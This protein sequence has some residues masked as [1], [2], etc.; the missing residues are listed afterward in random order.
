MRPR[1]T[2][3]FASLLALLLA[4]AA[5]ARQG[6]AEKVP[7]PSAE[8]ET[9]RFPPDD[10]G[11]ASFEA[12]RKAQERAV[13]EIAVPHGFRFT[14]QLPASGITFEHQVPADARLYYKPVHYDH[15]SPVVAADV[16]G[17][18]LLD[19][20]FLSLV[21]GNELWR[22]RGDGTF[23]EITARAGVGL[24]DRVGM[25]ASFADYDNDGDQDLFVTTVKTGNVLFANQGDG[26]F[27]DV[28]EKVGLDHVGHSSTGVF[29]D[30]D[31]DG[32]LD[33][34]LTNVGVYTTDEK[35]DYG[36]YLGVDDAFS[37]HL[38]PERT[39]R[40]IL[41]RNIEGKR[42]DDVSRKVGLV[43]RSW[44]G[45]ASFTDFDRDGWPELYVLNMQGDDHYYDNAEG[46]AFLDVTGKHFPKSPWGS[47]GVAFFDF[48]NDTRL[49]LILTDMHSDMSKQVPPSEETAK[50]DMQWPDD[51]LQGGEDNIFGNAFWVNQGDGEFVERSEALGTE[52]Y[53]PWGLS[54]GDLNADGFEDVVISASMS[55]PFR[56]GVNSVLL[57]DRGR[58]FVDAAFPLG[59]E[60][61]RDGRTHVPWFTLDCGGRDSWHALCQE[62][63]R[64]GRYQVT[65]PIGSR[66][67]LVADLDAD[68][69]LDI[70]T[71]DFGTVPQ[72]LL[73]NL[74]DQGKV[75]HLVIELV[76]TR[77]NRDGL[78]A[79]V[80]VE[81]GE[82]T[83]T[84][85]HDGQV[86]YLAHSPL[87]LYFGLGD[88]EKI[89]RV[90][91]EWPSGVV[92]TVSEGIIPGQTLE[93]VEP[94][95]PPA[96]ASDEETAGGGEGEGETG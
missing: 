55:Y 86:G 89:D 14:D 49:D 66:G 43:E 4:A 9:V 79:R 74:A 62:E 12:R 48:D 18:G 64:D 46:E 60:P 38:Y 70:V 56:Y 85:Y 57:N 54:V 93:I 22:N 72:I 92:Q 7:A 6:E 68:G 58:G 31:R 90:R 53:W 32:F 13:E 19:L 63:G 95:S 78:G 96:A 47:M 33:L 88:V 10:A 45:D 1:T 24:E 52:N 71:N 21:G 20:Y 81:A 3:A 15:G 16:D 51:F 83:W 73:S 80:T 59:V 29:F 17:D 94:E 39:E 76:G 75:H 27:E 23:E 87:P 34:F 5:P 28:T 77:S 26:R 84:R 25:A 91:V 65:G 37:G 2:L 61:R 30:Y 35:D 41:Y 69:D 40:S 82:R 67:V 50:S 36:V 8:L 11:V 42:F 44:S